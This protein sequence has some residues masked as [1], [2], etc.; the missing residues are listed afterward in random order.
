MAIPGVGYRVDGAKEVRKALR[1]LGDDLDDLKDLHRESAEI[2]EHQAETV[3]VPRE[4]GRLAD[5]I[6]S[7]GTKTKAIVRAGYASIPWAGPA[8]WGHDPRPQGGYMIA[9]PFL[10]DAYE[11]REAEVIDH[12]E[13]GLDELRKA[14]GL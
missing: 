13:D 8:H 6:R 12:Y 5:S 11:R 2:V 10:I 3:E 1:D 4:S 9:D 7:A 14:A